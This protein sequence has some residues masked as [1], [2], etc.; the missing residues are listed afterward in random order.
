VTSP[1]YGDDPSGTH[2]PDFETDDWADQD[3]LTKDEAR[4]RIEQTIQ[5][6]KGELERARRS[7][8]ERVPQLELYIERAQAVLEFIAKQSAPTFTAGSDPHGR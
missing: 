5:A 6:T 3:L 1:F 8:P 7:E 2:R 4:L